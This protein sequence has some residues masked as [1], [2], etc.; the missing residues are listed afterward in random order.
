MAGMFGREGE[1]VNM[2]EYLSQAYRI[3]RMVKAKLE[4]VMALRELSANAAATLSDMPKPTAPNIHRM[5]DIICKML[6]LESEINSDINALL[7]LKRDIMAAVRS[8]ENEDCRTLLE[9]RYLCFKSWIEIA[10]DL[11]FSKDHIFSLHRK[12]LAAVRLTV[13]GVE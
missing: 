2:K 3:D 7:D 8:V 6:D 1:S 11:R 4:Q 13:K 12:A 5:E 10:E 9:L